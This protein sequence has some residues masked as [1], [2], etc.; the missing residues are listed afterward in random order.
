MRAALLLNHDRKG[1]GCYNTG[2][3]FPNK[4]LRTILIGGLPSRM[5]RS[6]NS[7]SVNVSPRI[8]L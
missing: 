7:W 1:V 5:K 2:E 3:S 6:W 8:F 4:A